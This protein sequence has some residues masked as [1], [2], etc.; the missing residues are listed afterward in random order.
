MK[1]EQFFVVK[2]FSIINDFYLNTCIRRNDLFRLHVIFA[3]NVNRIRFPGI[4]SG[5]HD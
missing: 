5:F 4:G 2:K 3:F 1:I